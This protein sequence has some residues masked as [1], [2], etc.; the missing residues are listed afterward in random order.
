VKRLLAAGAL[1]L[2]A[3]PV[4]AVSLCTQTTTLY[5]LQS[6][7]AG[8][9]SLECLV[10]G[11]T[12]PYAR[13]D[14]NLRNIVDLCALAGPGTVTSVGLSAPSGFSVSG[15]PVIAAGSLSIT[16]DSQAAG[17]FYASPSGASGVP[18]FRAITLS[19]LSA[20]LTGFNAPT[21]T[22]ATTAGAAPPTGAAGGDLSGSYPNPSVVD[23]SHSHTA[24]TL[25]AGSTSA[26]GL[27]RLA[28]D[29]E[30]SAGKAMSSAD[31]RGSDART[32]LAHT[33]AASDLVSGSVARARLAG[34]YD[35]AVTGNA[36][37]ASSLDHTPAPCSAGMYVSAVAADGVLTCSTPAGGGGGSAP[38]NPLSLSG[39]RMWLSA[40]EMDA[41]DGDLVSA[42]YDMSGRGRTM[43]SSG[44]DRP[45]FVGGAV[46]NG[47]AAM[48]FDTAAQYM[49][50]VAAGNAV[51]DGSNWTFAVVFKATT[52]I[53]CTG[54]TY[55]SPAI[56]AHE[57]RFFG[58]AICDN[59]GVVE[60]RAYVWS[61]PEHTVAIPCPLNAWHVAAVRLSGGTL[62]LAVDGGSETTVSSGAPDDISGHMRIGTP[63][64][65]SAGLFVAELVMA[66]PSTSLASLIT[67][68][69]AYYGL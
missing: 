63:G 17:R 32:P 56:V 33:H 6:C 42:W 57:G 49:Q 12:I 30:V 3:S 25:P 15:A 18:A 2:L 59:G 58:L 52:A 14:A 45:T 69:M 21:A 26:L 10:Q 44:T 11:G 22:F 4:G 51:A 41:T 65:T 53:A 60:C 5:G 47:R 54:T 27:L 19:D 29:G 62:G 31:P 39:L 13:A 67:Y 28:T 16:A 24:A 46:S 8:Q 50:G 9:S 37:T 23:D 38:F 34:T 7:R 36:A 43:A 1:A 20:A 35:I 48:R 40:T 61:G 55:T 68:E 66:S 64:S